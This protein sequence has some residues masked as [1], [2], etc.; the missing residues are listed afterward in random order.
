MTYLFRGGD[1]SLF[2]SEESVEAL[3]RAQERGVVLDASHGA[4]S[5]D[6]G[7]ARQAMALGVEPNSISSDTSAFTG[8]LGSRLQQRALVR[9]VAAGLGTEQAI[10]ACSHV[11]GS[12]LGLEEDWPPN[13]EVG[14]FDVIRLTTTPPGAIVDLELLAVMRSGHLTIFEARPS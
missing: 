2:G 9:A 8:H 13:G 5:F 4:Y 3:R 7:V 14:D 6:D 10:L 11:P 12:V 1:A